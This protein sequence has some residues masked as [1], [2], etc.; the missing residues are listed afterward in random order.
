M[1][2]VPLPTGGSFNSLLIASLYFYSLF[3]FVL[4]F[5]N[6]KYNTIDKT[7]K[8]RSE[9]DVVQVS[10]NI[11]CPGEHKV[12]RKGNV[13]SVDMELAAFS[14]VHLAFYRLVDSE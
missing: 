14:E 13:I 12:G 6:F 11:G 10:L 5:C 3:C 9:V 2:H 4:F 8:Q 1:I 7:L